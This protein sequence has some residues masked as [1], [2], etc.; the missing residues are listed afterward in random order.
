MNVARRRMTKAL[1]ALESLRA[2]APDAPGVDG[3]VELARWIEEFHPQS[4]VEL[5]YGGLVDLMD[6]DTL[7]R[8]TSVE[9]LTEAL[10]ALRRGRTDLAVAAYERVLMWWRPLQAR[11]SAS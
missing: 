9:D 7:R 2:S 5:D 10:E 4:R 8:D 6:D 11:E 3:V 1:E